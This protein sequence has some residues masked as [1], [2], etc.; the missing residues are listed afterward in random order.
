[1]EAERHALGQFHPRHV[2][3]VEV[4][5]V[6]HRELGRVVVAVVHEGDQPAV[7]LLGSAGSGHEDRLTG[8]A[9]G[10]VIEYSTFAGNEVVLDGRPVHGGRIGLGAVAEPVRLSGER[11]SVTRELVAGRVDRRGRHALRGGIDLPTHQTR[12]RITER[13]QQVGSHH[14]VVEAHVQN[15]LAV[16]GVEGVHRM[17]HV[18]H[19]NVHPHDVG[20]GSL[21]RHQ[22]HAVSV[23][24]V[25]TER[26]TPRERQVEVDE[27]R[28]VVH[29]HVSIRDRHVVHHRH[30][31]QRDV[32]RAV[33]ATVLTH[34]DVL[35]VVHP[36]GP[37]V[38]DRVHLAGHRIELRM[39]GERAGQGAEEIVATHGLQLVGEFDG[40]TSG[41]H[42]GPRGAGEG[43][44][45][46]VRTT[47][48]VVPIASGNVGQSARR[49]DRGRSDVAIAVPLGP[50]LAQ[51]DS[52]HHA[53]TDEPVVG[54]GIDGPDRV[55]SVAQVT[56]VQL[57]WQLAD[58]RKIERGHLLGD[59]GVVSGQVA[60]VGDFVGQRGHVTVS[61]RRS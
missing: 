24:G 21:A 60:V 3:A 35:N 40:A 38:H 4:T 22:A 9:T 41:L 44:D 27:H 52:V 32:D 36:L 20:G 8:R 12:Q 33:H 18:A 26:E 49:A 6:E 51:S 43:A 45:V 34:A 19:R 13:T 46:R 17:E 42:H 2:A 1:M 10:T 61:S 48:R 30:A 29:H 39:S 56:T 28:L 59:R 54:R 37:R 31:R 11:T 23:F 47:R 14:H 55:R 50:T 58:H 5:G 53:V 7:V 16:G 25:P 57:A 15:D